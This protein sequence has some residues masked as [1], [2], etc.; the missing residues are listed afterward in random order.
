MMGRDPSGCNGLF[1]FLSE[2]E[3]PSPGQRGREGRRVLADDEFADGR[4]D[5]QKVG[6]GGY[7]QTAVAV[8]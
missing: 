7:G 8:G 6:G 3:F 5:G 1:R 4:A 2:S